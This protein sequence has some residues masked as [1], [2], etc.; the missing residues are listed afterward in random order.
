MSV[1]QSLGEY[2]LKASLQYDHHIRS[3]IVWH[4]RKLESNSAKTAWTSHISQKHAERLAEEAWTPIPA[5]RPK[6]KLLLRFIPPRNTITHPTLDTSQPRKP[7]LEGTVAVKDN[8][9]TS[10]LPTSCASDILRDYVA[11]K[12]ATV[13]RL[14]EDAGLTLLGKTNMDEFGMGSH[15]RNSAFGPM[16]SRGEAP[17]S[18]G[19]SSGGSALLVAQGLAHYALGTDTGGSVRLPASYLNIVGFKP[20]YGRISRYGVVPYANSLDTVGLFAKSCGD[21]IALFD[22][23]DKEDPNDPT[24]LSEGS[25]ARSLKL[26]NRYSGNAQFSGEDFRRGGT[27]VRPRRRI[28]VPTEYNI[29]EMQNGVREAWIRALNLLIAQGHDIVPISLS[30]TQQALSA[31]YVLAPAEASSNLAKYDGVRYGLPRDEILRDGEETLYSAHRGEHFGEEVRRRILLGAYTLS[32]G[33][34]DN[35]FIQAQ[36]VRRNV[37]NDFNRVF[38]H[39][40]PLLAKSRSAKDGVDYIVCPTAPTFPPKISSLEGASPL[41]AYTNDVFTVPASLAG[42]P[43]ISVPAPQSPESLG[44]RPE[45]AVG[46]QIIGQHGT[47]FPLL[48][49]A[50]S[51]FEETQ[52]WARLHAETKPIFK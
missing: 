3:Q 50:M 29:A 27:E 38:R 8:I 46:I 51:N 22:L 49:F 19:G 30:S 24:C 11:P 6:C 26:R 17:L 32:A 9:I 16:Q 5:K 41:E 25:R 28:G 40:H 2:G 44:Q 37:Q 1:F 10:H 18:V 15:S 20:S 34:M 42:L 14:M 4:L 52:D 43:A 12:K 35:F 47:D 39:P 7:Y 48:N 13:V 31:Y 36:K 23:L 45:R 33:A 21:I